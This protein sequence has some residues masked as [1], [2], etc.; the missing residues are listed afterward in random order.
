VIF[1]ITIGKTDK[2][3]TKNLS[4]IVCIFHSP[5]KVV[6][7]RFQ[8]MA[9]IIETLQGAPT[10]KT[11][12]RA[13]QGAN[14]NHVLAGSSPITLFAPTD[15]AFAKLPKETL[16]ALLGDSAKLR[17]VLTHHIV[18]GRVSAA[19][20][21]SIGALTASDGKTL[22]IEQSNGVQVGKAKIVQADLNCD[23]GFI[24]IIDSVAE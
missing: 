10:L 22:A 2:A 18:A 12:V 5:V 19:D 14:L 15:E 21:A 13:I 24:H 20:I 9:T 3:I 4:K 7:G 23:D 8:K 16:D 11:L 17:A 1:K 6:A